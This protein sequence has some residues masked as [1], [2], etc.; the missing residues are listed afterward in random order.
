M[1]NRKI[2]Q[3]QALTILTKSQQLVIARYSGKFEHGEMVFLK[4]YIFRYTQSVE[5]TQPTCM[6]YIT[7]VSCVLSKLKFSAS[8]VLIVEKANRFH[9]KK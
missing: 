3:I 2:V 7:K 1:K 8:L 4:V 9:I 6:L 5:M